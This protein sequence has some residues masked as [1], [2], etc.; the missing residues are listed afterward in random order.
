[1][2]RKQRIWYPGATYHV[3]ARGIRRMAI[4]KDKWD[5][6]MFLSTLDIARDKKRFTV[7]SANEYG[8]EVKIS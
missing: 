5:Y 2:P 1:M 6:E 7:A 8:V 3:M 4:Y